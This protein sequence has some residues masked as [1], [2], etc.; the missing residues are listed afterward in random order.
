MVYKEDSNLTFEELLEKDKSFSTH[1]RNLQHLAILMY[2]V[3]N[4]LAPARV[5]EIFKLNYENKL[6]RFF[7][8]GFPLC[9]TVTPCRRKICATPKKKIILSYP[10]SSLHLKH[11]INFCS[12]FLHNTIA[13]MYVH[14]FVTCTY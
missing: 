3:K 11:L 13:N 6:C 8:A 2:Q 4:G 12:N 1:P 5:Q 7:E 14:V 10:S 9:H